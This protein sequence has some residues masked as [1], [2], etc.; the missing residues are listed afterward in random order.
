MLE[1]EV[2]TK[3]LLEKDG[4]GAKLEIRGCLPYEETSVQSA[5]Y[6]KASNPIIRPMRWGGVAC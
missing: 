4:L 6:F 5:F 1:L 3:Q 2:V